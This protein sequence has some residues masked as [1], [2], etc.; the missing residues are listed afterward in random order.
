ML[1]SVYNEYNRIHHTYERRPHTHTISE[2]DIADTTNHIIGTEWNFFF[3]R[4]SL[5]LFIQYVE[6][7]VRLLQSTLYTQSSVIHSFHTDISS[8]MLHTVRSS[9]ECIDTQTHER[10][11]VLIFWS[12]VNKSQDG[13]AHLFARLHNPQ[14]CKLISFVHFGCDYVW[15]ALPHTTS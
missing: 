4:L 1:A 12:S 14:N 8:S 9:G 13:S 2:S 3:F 10:F 7:I 11:F 5:I 6:V 15:D